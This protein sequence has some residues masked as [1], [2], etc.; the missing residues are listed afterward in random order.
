VKPIGLLRHPK[1]PLQDGQAIRIAKGQ[2][3][4]PKAPVDD[5]QKK[6]WGAED[7]KYEKYIRKQK[8]RQSL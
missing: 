7:R 6:V 8:E 1:T 2:A 3:F 5:N 4:G